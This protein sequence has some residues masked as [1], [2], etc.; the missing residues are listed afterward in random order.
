MKRRDFITRTALITYVLPSLTLKAC[1]TTPSAKSNAVKEGGHAEETF[2]L[3]ESTIEGL[4]QLMA[5][6]KMTSRSIVELFLKRIEA[7]DKT[8]PALNSII[9]LNPESR[10]IADRMDE[11]RKKGKLRGPLHGIPFLVKDNIDTGDKM[12]TTAGSLALK[13]HYASED[14][15]IIRQ[16]REAGAVLLGKTNLSEWANFRSN[17]S[18]SG[19][20]SRGG[21]TKNPY[22]LD[23]NPCGSSSGSGVAVAANLCAFAIGT[24]TNG[25][26]ACP[27]SINGIVGLKP[28]VGLVSRSG[29]I[30]ISKTQDTAG[31]MTR[32]I[33]DAAIVLGALTAVDEKD[34]IMGNRSVNIPADYTIFLDDNSLQGKKIGVEKSFLKGHEAIDLLLQNAL[35]QMIA[36][37]A[38]IVEVNLVE[39]LKD[40]SDNEFKV[41]QYEFKDGLNRYLA[42]KN[43]PVKSLLDVITFNKEHADEV[44]PYFRQDILESSQEKGNLDSQD[45]KDA[46]NKILTVSRKAIDGLMQEHGLVAICG[47]ANGPTWCTDLVNG[48]SFTGYGM[49]SAAAIAG[50]PSITVP[51]G[52]VEG[53]PIGI[54]FIGKPFGEG[55][56][57][58]IGYAYEQ[59]SKNRKSPAYKKQAI[60][61][62]K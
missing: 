46:L 17:R 52:Q 36:K 41:L 21:Q 13:G 38:S 56:L 37:G 18:S 48:D 12:M 23:R 1:Q 5:Q 49:Y 22:S 60:S 62:K 59:A 57:L 3:N 50:Y 6:G 11:E 19:W 30:P 39:R 9:E 45:Y 32:T 35:K 10:E 61:L 4:Q 14:A 44:M 33:Q 53:L 2:E 58:G 7:I 51:L 47:P 8:G 26:I 42:A 29:I 54:S 40:I 15:A 16:L 34:E 25:S 31:P 24:E 28:T 20:S 55:E 27:S 43:L